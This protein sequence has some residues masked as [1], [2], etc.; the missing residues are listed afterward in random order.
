MTR[1]V[2]AALFIA[3]TFVPAAAEAPT[4]FLEFAW[5]TS[6]TVIRQQFMPTRC[7]SVTESHQPWYSLE[8]HGYL[9]EGL[10]IP[11]LRLDFEPADSLAGYHMVIARGSYR[12][13]RD[14]VLQRFGRP[15]SRNNPLLWSGAQ[16]AWVWNGVSAT[17]IERCGEERSCIEVRTTVLDRKRAELRERE[18]RDSMQSF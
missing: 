15:T 11:V 7:R 6:P 10:S 8:C 18:R 4:G 17:L 9:V 13:F 1:V 2:L 14:L 3:V 12:A 5:G 16:A